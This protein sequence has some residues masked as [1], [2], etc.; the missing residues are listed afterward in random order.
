MADLMSAG[1]VR[2]GWSRTAP[3]SIR[4]ARFT[5]RPPAAPQAGPLDSADT[6]RLTL[7]AGAQ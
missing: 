2:A 3:A 4:G 7:S 6:E 1:G 5:D